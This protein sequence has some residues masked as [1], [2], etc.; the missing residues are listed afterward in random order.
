[1]QSSCSAPTTQLSLQDSSVIYGF[2]TDETGKLKWDILGDYYPCIPYVFRV[3]TSFRPRG[4]IVCELLSQPDLGWRVVVQELSFGLSYYNSP[5]YIGQGS[6]VWA[7]PDTEYVQPDYA[8]G[9][10]GNDH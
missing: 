5:Y 7:L 8:F 9:Y 4:S 1:M 2:L 6:N 3:S 10:Q